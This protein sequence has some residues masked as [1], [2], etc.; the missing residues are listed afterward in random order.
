MNASPEHQRI[1][2][3][4]ADL[5]R[6]IAQAERARTKP[7][8]A[9]RIAELVAIRQEQLRELTALTGTRDDVRTEL[10][11]LESDVKLVEQRR[12]RDADRLATSTNPKDAQALEHEI[13]SLTRRQSD[14]EDIELDVMGRV[15]DADAAVAAQQALLATTTAEGTALTAQAKADV[16]AATDLAAQLARDRDAVTAAVPAPL[17]AEYTRRASNSAGAALLT[18][19]TC[20]GCRILLPGTDLND[21]RN[22]PDDLVVSCPECGCILVRTEETGL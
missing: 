12:A 2:L 19:G 15:E 6:R 21:I 5:D 13:A 17:L 7:S 20:E 9:A 1:L 10:T 16:Q 3:D 8:Q 11:R 18:R 22:A 14:L 4:V